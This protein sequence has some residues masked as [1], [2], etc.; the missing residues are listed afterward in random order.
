[1]AKIALSENEQEKLKKTA[2][3]ELDRLETIL[4]NIETVAALDEF[5][6]KFNICE[7]VYKFILKEYNKKSNKNIRENDLKI[8]MHQVKAAMLFAGYSIEYDILTKIFG[9]IPH[10]AKTLRNKVTHSLDQKAVE[11]I[12][13]RKEELF[14]LMDLFLNAI[15]NSE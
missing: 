8:N 13:N 1:M 10:S 14:C 7:T 12:T 6:N 15:R 5:K 11:E 3:S 4:K 2:K 9:S